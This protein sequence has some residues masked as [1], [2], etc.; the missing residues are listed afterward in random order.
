[1]QETLDLALPAQQAKVSETKAVWMDYYHLGSGLVSFE[2]RQ[3]E[4]ALQK[5]NK[6]KIQF[7]H[8]SEKLESF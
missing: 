4:Q 2:Q 6:E 7:Q 1:M 8:D 5:L 3:D